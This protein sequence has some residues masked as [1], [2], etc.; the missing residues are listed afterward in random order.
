MLSW[1]NF[2]VCWLAER[3]I[4]G[5]LNINCYCEWENAKCWQS[6]CRDFASIYMMILINSCEQLWREIR[7]WNCC[8]IAGLDIRIMSWISLIIIALLPSLLFKKHQIY[9]QQ[10]GI[11]D[12]GEFY[13]QDAW[14]SCCKIFSNYS[15]H[16]EPYHQPSLPFLSFVIVRFGGLMA[17]F[18]SLSWLICRCM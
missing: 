11:S 17:S 6:V 1:I 7:K 12:R 16:V 10:F 3:C 9:N 13:W 15:N 14:I 4:A 2:S 5:S 8:K 18:L